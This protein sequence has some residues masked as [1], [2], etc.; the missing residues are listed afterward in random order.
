MLEDEH[1]IVSVK[2]VTLSQHSERYQ[3]ELSS[4]CPAHHNQQNAVAAQAM[5]GV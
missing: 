5:S 2:K 4:L 1:G 3:A